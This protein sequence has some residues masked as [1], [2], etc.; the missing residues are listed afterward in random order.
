M[1]YTQVKIT[2]LKAGFHPLLVIWYT[3]VVKWFFF[4]GFQIYLGIFR[5]IYHMETTYL[6]WL[7]FIF[8]QYTDIMIYNIS[9][10]AITPS[11]F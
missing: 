8:I 7:H 4:L 2:D 5:V 9:I 3:K 11:V 1:L 10:Q 6:T